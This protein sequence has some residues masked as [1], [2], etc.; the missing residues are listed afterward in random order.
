V[1]I[2]LSSSIIFWHLK[3]IYRYVLGILLFVFLVGMWALCNSVYHEY[4]VLHP[5]QNVSL[6]P[7]NEEDA[8]VKLHW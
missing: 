1:T 7:L 8:H 2:F 5:V 3:R 4:H 6:S